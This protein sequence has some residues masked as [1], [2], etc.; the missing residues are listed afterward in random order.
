MLTQFYGL[1]QCSH[2]ACCAKAKVRCEN[3]MNFPCIDEWKTQ[4]VDLDF[5]SGTQTAQGL[6]PYSLQPA[7]TPGSLRKP[8]NVRPGSM[9]SSGLHN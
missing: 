7:T 8:C 6:M 3:V 1:L 5:V 9:Q 4:T 2:P